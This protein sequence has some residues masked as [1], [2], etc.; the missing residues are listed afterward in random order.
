MMQP[1]Y[2]GSIVDY[3]HAVHLSS[4]HLIAYASIKLQLP[5]VAKQNSDKFQEKKTQQA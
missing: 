4:G 1:P 2:N 3:W 5:A